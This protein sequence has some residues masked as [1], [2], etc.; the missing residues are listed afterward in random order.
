MNKP[1][2]LCRKCDMIYNPKI[3]GD[4]DGYKQ[5]KCTHCGHEQTVYV[6][7]KVIVVPVI[8]RFKE[9]KSWPKDG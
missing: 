6:A 7:F 1:T 8:T 4:K 9:Q 2:V 3:E 5:I